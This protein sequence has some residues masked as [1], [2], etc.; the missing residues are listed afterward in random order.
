MSAA[1]QS[2]A[3]RL[4][5]G[6]FVTFEQVP[7]NVLGD[8]DAGMSEGLRDHVQ[9]RALDQH[10]RRPRVAQL[11]GMPVTQPRPLAQPGTQAAPLRG[12]GSGALR[13]GR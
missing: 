3:H 7:V 12:A 2:P 9:W 4:S 8:S 10:Q 6:T 13:D 5:N 11:V 1:E